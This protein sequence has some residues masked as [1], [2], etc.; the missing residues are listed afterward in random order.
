MICSIEMVLQL[1]IF[2][3]GILGGFFGGIGAG[4]YFEKR[5]RKNQHLSE[6]ASAV[7][8]EILCLYK[9]GANLDRSL[10]EWHHESINRL[11][12]FAD[13]MKDFDKCR[14]RKIEESYN[15]YRPPNGDYNEWLA[16][17]MKLGSRKKALEKKLNGLL[18]KIVKA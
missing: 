8:S 1:L 16:K 17:S 18:S 7:R 6:F 2:F 14:W 4:I 5:S 11:D 15:N 3:S 9:K 12:R 10:R 13:Y